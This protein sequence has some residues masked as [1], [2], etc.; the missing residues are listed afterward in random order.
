ML[1]SNDN[2]DEKRNDDKPNV[3]GGYDT[4]LEVG[5]KH[6]NQSNS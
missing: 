3:T 5:E 6:E 1:K 4:P 2:I